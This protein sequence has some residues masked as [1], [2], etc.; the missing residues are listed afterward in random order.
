MIGVSSNGPKAQALLAR[1]V[2]GVERA[3]VC[4]GLRP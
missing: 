3:T 4:F 2:V 1:G